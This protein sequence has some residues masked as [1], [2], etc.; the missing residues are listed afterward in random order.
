MRRSTIFL[1]AGILT[2]AAL[3]AFA[4]GTPPRQDVPAE[5]EVALPEV[6]FVPIDTL[7]PAAQADSDQEPAEA[8]EDSTEKAEQPE[9]KKPS[10]TDKVEQ[11]AAALRIMG[12]VGTGL[13][14][15][16]MEDLLG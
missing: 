2:V 6:V 12:R 10:L 9:E 14:K 3:S 16:L 1:L 15:N 13:I 7:T 4:Q 11:G 5:C 8:T